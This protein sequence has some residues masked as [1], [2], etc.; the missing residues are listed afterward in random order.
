V[1]FETD[2]IMSSTGRCV[3]FKFTRHDVPDARFRHEPARYN[4][5]QYGTFNSVS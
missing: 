5:G 2:P 1:E 4:H 3:K